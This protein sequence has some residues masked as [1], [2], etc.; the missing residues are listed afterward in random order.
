MDDRDVT[1]TLARVSMG[2][3]RL[4]TA[5][6]Q[7]YAYCFVVINGCPRLRQLSAADREDCVQDVM[8]ELVRRFGEDV[9]EAVEG[10]LEGWIRVVSRNKAADIL[11]RRYRKPEVRF[12][13]GAGGGILDGDLDEGE[14]DRQR[15]EAVSL[16]WEALLRLDHQVSV[17]SYLIFYLRTIE[18]WSIP[19]TAEL[20]G[21]TPEQ[22]RARCHRVRKKFDAILRACG[23][24]G[25]DPPSS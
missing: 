25:A 5:W 16:V 3:P 6:D 18:G 23:P 17:T 11:R 19:E 1:S 13:D 2:D 24:D 7:F 4:A 22:V 14:L 8:M 12:A 10:G 21:I 15:G 9:P 20:F